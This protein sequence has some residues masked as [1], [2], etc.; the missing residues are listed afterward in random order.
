MYFNHVRLY[1]SIYVRL[2]CEPGNKAVCLR[3]AISKQVMQSRNVQTHMQSTVRHRNDTVKEI[4]STR[5]ISKQ[6]A[7]LQR[8]NELFMDSPATCV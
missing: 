4:D 3:Q 6:R 2:P 5:P 1:D 8:E 7:S